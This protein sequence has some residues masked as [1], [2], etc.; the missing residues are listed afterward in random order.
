MTTRLLMSE[1]AKYIYQ[2][3]CHALLGFPDAAVDCSL[4]IKNQKVSSGAYDFELTFSGDYVFTT[5][6]ARRAININVATGVV[7]YQDA[8]ISEDILRSVEVPENASIV[9]S[10]TA[11]SLAS[12]RR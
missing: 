4:V 1:L 12:S 7:P 11:S 5:H 9:V 3:W 8:L 2:T 6:F 10:R